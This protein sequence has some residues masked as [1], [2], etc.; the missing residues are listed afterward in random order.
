MSYWNLT[1]WARTEPLTGWPALACAVIALAVPTII[2][3]GMNETVTGCEFTAYL[4]FLLICAFLLRWWQAAAVAISSAAIVELLCKCPTA[5]SFTSE[6]FLTSAGIFL[7]SSAVMIVAA[8]IVRKVIASLQ[9][10]GED[11]SAG[12]IIFSLERGVVWA[13]WYGQCAPM[14]L[15]SS[16]RVSEMMKDFL[17]QEELARRLNGSS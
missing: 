8:A 11:E 10:R 13:S 15:G 4:P 1:R 14:R 5:K 7:A 6:C 2:R 12:G 3:A 17:A 16:R 9:G